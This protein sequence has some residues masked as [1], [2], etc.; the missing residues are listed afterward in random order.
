M[1]RIV[2]A[3]DDGPPRAAAQVRGD[4][5]ALLLGVAC[6][7]DLD[8]RP[9]VEWAV[10]RALERGA[11][12]LFVRGPVRLD[13]PLAG[14]LEAAGFRPLEVLRHFEAEVDRLL[15]R[16]EPLAHQLLAERP[17][18]AD[19]ARLVSVAV[20]G[21]G[22]FRERA[23][24][25]VESQLGRP[26]LRYSWTRSCLL[27]RERELLGCCLTHGA[28]IP[29]V[30]AFVVRPDLRMGWATVLLRAWGLRFLRDR[31]IE[32]VRYQ[33]R[34]GDHG[35]AIQM[36]RRAD[37]RALPSKA[38]YGLDLVGAAATDRSVRAAPTG[39]EP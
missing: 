8:P 25:L 17:E 14:A 22:G 18:L 39:E 37:A 20:G 3:E 32:K 26:P 7:G 16:V 2:L 23:E 15:A 27:L 28:S 35:Q 4:G 13:R 24:E 38:T 36:G 5:E 21:A 30:Q 6:P 10:E 31:G 11:R 34:E 33:A 1:D 29:T 12:R 9:L 19:G